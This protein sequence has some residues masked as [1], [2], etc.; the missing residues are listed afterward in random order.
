[1]NGIPADDDIRFL[2]ALNRELKMGYPVDVRDAVLRR[3]YGMSQICINTR[4]CTAGMRGS[5]LF[6]NYPRGKGITLETAG[7]A[8]DE[9]LNSVKQSNRSVLIGS[10]GS[11]LDPS[12]VPE[13]ILDTILDRLSILKG[14]TIIF[15]SRLEPI[16]DDTLERIGRTLKSNKI[17]IEFGLEAVDPFILRYCLNKHINLEDVKK[18]ISS[19][20][21]HGFTATANTRRE[22]LR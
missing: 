16:T 11:V 12:E 17:N 7:S 14:R 5:C 22:Q 9:L 20:R 8:M 18:K 19:I 15:E 21:S 3:Q 10:C 2:N 13:E 1:M 6:C 4:G